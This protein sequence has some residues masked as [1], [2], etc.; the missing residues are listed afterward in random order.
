M[1]DLVIV[2][3][4]GL[5]KEV[6]WLAKRSGINVQGF[7]DDNHAL[8]GREFYRKPVLGTVADWVHFS[9]AQFVIAIAAP[10]IKKK[11]LKRMEALGDPDF[12]TLIDPS[13]QVDLSET[14]VGKGSVICAGTVCT[15]D[16]VIGTHCSIN[17]LCSIGHDAT[18]HDFVT[19]S[20]Q[21]ML[22]G[23][24]I[25][26]KGAEVG[27]ASLV[28]QSLAVGPG[29]IVGMGAVVTKDV[30]PDVTV[31]GNPAKVFAPRKD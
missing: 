23:Q 10:H 28:R 14:V 9:E 3:A 4:S 7:L 26:G 21:V 5:G 16:T 2:G 15:A 13:A 30:P 31:V 12:A 25:V 17:K 24:S 20:P 6:A 29:A 1:K 19:L 18:I 27:A 11:I 22:G 8:E